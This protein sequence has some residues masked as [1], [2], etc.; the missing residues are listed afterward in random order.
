MSAVLQQQFRTVG[1]LQ[2]H[3]INQRIY[4]DEA[5]PDE[6]VAS[7]KARGI[8]E[9]IQI[10]SDGTI[11]SGHRR[12]QAAKQV[13]LDAVP[14]TICDYAS[15]LDERLA[16]I[17]FNRQREKTFT[18]KMNE[19]E[20]LEAIEKE[21]AKARKAATQLAGKDKEGKHVTASVTA[22]LPEPNK[23]ETREKVAKQTGIGSARTYDTAK[24]LW[25][26][27]KEGDEVAAKLVEA[28]DQKKE[29]ISGAYKKLEKK[30][31]ADQIA[32]E[33]KALAESVKEVPKSTMFEVACCDLA[34]YEPPELV[35]VIITDPPYPKEFLPLWSV[36]A[37]KANDWL[38][39]GGLLVAMSGQVY[40][41]QVYAML[42]EHLD[43]YW[44]A[45]YHT[46]GQPTPLRQV[47]VN[48]TWKPLLI[49]KRSGEKYSGRIF[50][51][52]MKS[53]QNEKDFHKWGQSVSGME[54]IL[55]RFALPG[56]TV[57]DPF[58]G[59]GTTGVAAIKRG[60][61]FYGCELEQENV[62]ISI[63]R[64]SEASND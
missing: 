29:S 22:K 38:K 52:F 60:C 58:C 39:P 27:A 37:K 25:T 56:Q 9:P 53:D 15:G 44:T 64:I 4:G 10:K 57:L 31:R 49:Y 33:R 45:C 28:V 50:G 32:A 13:G 3:A 40:L 20:E 35:D 11:I 5:L 59:A 23:G 8:L 54:A 1:S 47:N 12:W 36:L 21:R 24:K 63:A 14:V 62:S 30:E 61:K 7:I 51:D 19:A 55:E 17:E 48:T 18:Q 34:Q 16:L 26:K 43:Y 42:S 6:F 46:P 2:A 41:D